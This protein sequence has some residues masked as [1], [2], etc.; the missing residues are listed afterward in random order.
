MTHDP[1]SLRARLLV[2]VAQEPGLNAQR[3]ALRLQANTSSCATMLKRLC[4][5]G[6]L[7]RVPWYRLK[8]R[9]VYIPVRKETP[10]VFAR[11]QRS[12]G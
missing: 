1:S 2:V 3:Y 8:H 10:R 11:Y 12:Q 4:D 7:I 6:E 9:W 5:A